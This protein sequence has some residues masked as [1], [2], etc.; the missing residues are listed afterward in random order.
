MKRSEVN[1]VLRAGAALLREQG[2][3]LPPFAAWSPRELAAR[4][5]GTEIETAHL[6]WDVTDYGEG[7]F[8][9]LGIVQFIL[10]RGPGYSEKVLVSRHDQ[11]TPM[12][13]HAAKIHDLVNRGGAQL[14]VEM[15]GSDAHGG[16]DQ[17]RGVRVLVDGV[18]RDFD[19]GEVLVL[20]PGQSVML[21][22]GDW[23]AFWGQ[24][25]DVVVGEIGNEPGDPGD[26]LFR[27]PLARFPEVEE[28]EPPLHLLVSDYPRWMH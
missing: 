9:N 7:N 15:F 14:A 4:G 23:H 5:Q 11:I 8:A 20:D 10:R 24:G 28:D 21:Q 27:K 17:H 3:A 26:T 2:V 12:H 16:F 18:W 19:P 13:R 22:P 25:G 6:G 1:E